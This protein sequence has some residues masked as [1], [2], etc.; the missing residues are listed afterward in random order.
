MNLK[1]YMREVR[2]TRPELNGLSQHRI[3]SIM[4]VAG[5]AGELLDLIKK[6][7]FQGHPYDHEKVIEELGD[8][9]WYLVYFMDIS[10]VSVDDIINYN[11]A[12]LRV[13]YPQGFSPQDSIKRV[14]TK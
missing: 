4:G 11:V 7:E 1:D 3:N 8:I 14:D 5:E 13:R 9:L 2:R 6:V 12:K 10:S